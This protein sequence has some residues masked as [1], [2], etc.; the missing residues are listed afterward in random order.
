MSSPVPQES[1]PD[2][3]KRVLKVL[4]SIYELPAPAQLP[5]AALQETCNATLEKFE[6]LM[7][8]TLR[9][10]RD[11]ISEAQKLL[12]EEKAAFAVQSDNLKSERAQF[13]AD[14]NALAGQR[15]V[16][17]RDREQL[18]ADQASFHRESDACKE[19]RSNLESEKKYLA[20]LRTLHQER[21][22]T[23]ADKGTKL[24]AAQRELESGQWTLQDKLEKLEADRKQLEAVRE[25]VRTGQLQLRTDQSNLATA[26]KDL[27]TGQS[28][29][30]SAQKALEVDQSELAAAQKA[31]AADQSNL[32]AA[33]KA[34]ESGQSEL[35]TA[36]KVLEAEKTRLSADQE[37][38]RTGQVDLEAVKK[39]LEESKA[40][41][42]AGRTRLLSDQTRLQADQK[43]LGTGQQEL[44]RERATL[45][46]QQQVLGRNQE[47]LLQQ[48]WLF[49]EREDVLGKVQQ[50]LGTLLNERLQEMSNAMG[51]LGQ[52]VQNTVS[53]LSGQMDT[54][55][56]ELDSGVTELKLTTVTW[57]GNAARTSA[58]SMTELS[59]T[60]NN[61][62]ETLQGALAGLQRADT[63][64]SANQ[65][66]VEKLESLESV[67]TDSLVK[68][69]AGN[70]P[71]QLE[72]L[73]GALVVVGQLLE[74]AKINVDK[75]LRETAKKVDN[76][77]QESL[78]D[79]MKE[80][81]HAS[82]EAL[83]GQLRE[84]ESKVGKST[85]R[86][87][88]L[89]TKMD[90]MPDCLL[91][92][93]EA[94][95]ARIGE[96]KEGVESLQDTMPTAEATSAE[97]SGLKEVVT[98]FSDNLGGLAT[99]I[100]GLSGKPRAEMKPDFA[101]LAN[102]LQSLSGKIV[103]VEGL[104]RKLSE[105]EKGGRA[106]DLAL[107]RMEVEKG[108]L[109]RSVSQHEKQ[110]ADIRKDHEKR[111]AESRLD[112]EKRLADSRQ[113]L[114]TRVFD[115]Q[116]QLAESRKEHEKSRTELEKYRK[117]ADDIFARGVEQAARASS[118]HLGV[119]ER[120]LGKRSAVESAPA[121]PPTKRARTNEHQI[122]NW[123]R[124]MAVMVEELNLDGSG[125]LDDRAF[126]YLRDR[127]IDYVKFPHKYSRLR[128][129]IQARDPIEWT[130]GA[131]ITLYGHEAPEAKGCRCLEAE[132]WLEDEPSFGCTQ[133]TKLGNGTTQIRRVNDGP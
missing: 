52:D 37:E 102:N 77:L 117:N 87:G 46:Q 29:L 17:E 98:G 67:I 9:D 59:N 79:I 118:E 89:S 22:Q 62:Q 64:Q 110:L 57:V 82:D 132:S 53:G 90:G 45:S 92:V 99:Q 112:L 5:V 33:Q 108:F 42:E 4:A 49:E 121:E 81:L 111:L 63:A 60:V 10:E 133:L 35:A 122:T 93:T 66:L 96:L 97:F 34:L 124:E 38:V 107:T 69:A 104:R 106:K 119:I 36:Q 15:E 40:E 105:E 3:F 30:S 65:K 14:K 127:I 54:L 76:V 83:S 88:S 24:E 23:Q 26:Q 128:D 123:A 1:A 51:S 130:C 25:Q 32:R 101:D 94:L 74:G 73:R 84:I 115:H 120:V 43:E 2:A 131:A 41:L 95:S 19:L 80:M 86:V 116:T 61:L 56:R 6:I 70:I 44:G 12:N 13:D 125:T 8:G 11:G 39:A 103:E 71:G 114:E 75:V 109:G 21:L 85:E 48:Q 129:F 18:A 72:Q 113:D 27:E 55:R 100:D 28:K 126:N 91:K 16:I 20:E 68:E 78:P 58:N 31:L 7:K 47:A 50:S